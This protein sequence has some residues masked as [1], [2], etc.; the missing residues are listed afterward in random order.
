MRTTG[1]IMTILAIQSTLFAQNFHT[2]SDDYAGMVKI[3]TGYY[4]PFLKTSSDDKKTEPIKVHSYYL[5]KHPVTNA[6]FLEFI[7]ANPKW[8]RSKSLSI[9]TDKNYLSQWAGDFEIGNKAIHDSPVT[10]ISW[11]AA[12]AYAKWKGR[13]LPTMQEWEYAAQAPPIN[14]KK[15][16]KLSSIILDWYSYPTPDILPNVESTFKNTYGLYDMHGLVWEWVADFNSI[17]TTGGSGSTGSIDPKY[18]CA[19]AS[20]G[21][22][23]KEDYA[24]FMRFAF[25]ESLKAKYTIR[26]LGFRCAQDLNED[27]SISKR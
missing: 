14:M 4:Q 20:L 23:D 18:Y 25:R 1:I 24:S 26:S 7:K 8:A 27:T 21:V 3:P 6:A 10:N 2:K 15:G 17:I 13:R 16:Q 22:T 12:K 11:Y 19:S 5:D 9:F